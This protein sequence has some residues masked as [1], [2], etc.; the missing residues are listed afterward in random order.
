M[1]EARVNRAAESLLM[2]GIEVADRQEEVLLEA[3]A[4]KEVYGV[5]SSLDPAVMVRTARDFFVG[6]SIDPSISDRE[7]RNRARGYASLIRTFG[8]K[9]SEDPTK[10]FSTPS[11][12]KAEG[13]GTAV[14][15]ARPVADESDRLRG[16]V[17]DLQLE[18]EAM[19]K[20]LGEGG[21]ADSVAPSALGSGGGRLELTEVLK[22]QTEVLKKAFSNKGPSITTVK[23]DLHWP[24]LSDDMTGVKD[25]AEFYESFEDNCGLAN[26]CQGMSKR[27]MLIALRSRCKGSRLKTFQNIYRQEIRAGNVEADPASVYE[28]IKSKHLLFSESVE[29]R[30]IRVDSEHAALLKGKLTGHQFEPLFARSIAELEEIGLGK[31]PRELFLSYLRKVGPVLQKEIRKDKR[32]WPKETELRAPR[33]WEEAHKVVLEYEQRDSTNRAQVSSVY[34]AEE[35]PRPRR[36]SKGGE[37]SVLNTD[38]G[39]G[40]GRKSK[41]CF[42]SV[43]MGTVPRE[44]SVSTPMTKSCVR[45]LLRSSVLAEIVSGPRPIVVAKA[46]RDEAVE[47]ETARAEIALQAVEGLDV[48]VLGGEQTRQTGEETEAEVEGTSKALLPEEWVV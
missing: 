4:V 48:T 30:E 2:L 39:K 17:A 9:A 26:N 32:I 1:F 14:S 31:T 25:V 36:Q 43:T 15:A 34:V 5:T 42:N 21:D 40:A 11:V 46:V 3:S 13:G 23:T 35:T 16:K 24:T 19:R 6:I 20:K 18:L 12:V 7:R 37:D 27:E 38:T 28:R 44:I 33:S 41:I 10:L 45:R 29:E 8:G 47:R 22:E